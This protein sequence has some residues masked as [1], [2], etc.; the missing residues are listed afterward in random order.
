MKYLWLSL[1]GLI[2][3]LMLIIFFQN[4]AG[5]MPADVYY[6]TVADSMNP[7]VVLF[8]GFLFGVIGTM[9][10]IMYFTGGKMPTANSD[11]SGGT[12]EW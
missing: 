3:L 9:S 12:E 2:G 10:V 4:L 6:L 1:G 8:W 11:F 7:G 5:A